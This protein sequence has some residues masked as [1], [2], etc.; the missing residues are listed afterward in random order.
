MKVMRKAYGIISVGDRVLIFREQKA[1][2]EDVAQFPGGTIEDEESIEAGLLRE[3]HEES[4]LSDLTIVRQLGCEVRRPTPEI[5]TLRHFYLLHCGEPMK[6]SWLHY[7]MFSSAH[8][9]PLPYLYSW[10]L[11]DEAKL[12]MGGDHHKFLHLI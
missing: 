5:T 8:D 4:G 10:M 6:E 9:A 11:L 2:G 1:D 12:G 3:V 7:E